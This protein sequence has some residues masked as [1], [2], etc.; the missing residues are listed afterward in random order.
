[1]ELQSLEFAQLV[2]DL[3]LVQYFLTMLP[4]VW[5]LGM[6]MYILCHYMSEGRDLPFYF[7]FTGDYS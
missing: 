7:D 2:P 4:S 5:S 6:V 3:A 1:M